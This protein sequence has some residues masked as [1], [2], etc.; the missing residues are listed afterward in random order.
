MKLSAQKTT[1]FWNNLHQVHVGLILK[2]WKAKHFI[3][4]FLYRDKV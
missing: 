3:K 1:R 2:C 4:V